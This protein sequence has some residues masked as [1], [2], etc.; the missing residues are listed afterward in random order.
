L[1]A[2][3][4]HDDPGLVTGKLDRKELPP[5]PAGPKGVALKGECTLTVPHPN[6]GEEFVIGCGLCREISRF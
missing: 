6:P 4:C 1:L 5:C 2:D 3:P